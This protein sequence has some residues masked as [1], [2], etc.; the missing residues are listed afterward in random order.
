[1]HLIYG[2]VGFCSYLCQYSVQCLA[3]GLR[4]EWFVALFRICFWHVWKVV[5]GRPKGRQRTIKRFQTHRMVSWC[6]PSCWVLCVDAPERSGLYSV[7]RQT[8][9]KRREALQT[10]TT[11]AFLFERSVPIFAS[12]PSKTLMYFST[13]LVF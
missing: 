3:L 11:Q 6:P 9:T 5:E 8:F 1:M 7:L 10:L 13:T 12:C 2:L 4:L